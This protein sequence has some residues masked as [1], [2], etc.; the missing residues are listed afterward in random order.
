MRAGLVVL[1]ICWYVQ[2]DE[3]QATSSDQAEASWS[4]H[5]TAASGR[6]NHWSADVFI[7]QWRWGW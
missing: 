5:C 4:S 6:Y 2:D 1:L 3:N 7:G